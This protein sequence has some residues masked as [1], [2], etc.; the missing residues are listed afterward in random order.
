MLTYK[1]ALAGLRSNDK[2]QFLKDLLIQHKSGNENLTAALNPVTQYYLIHL[3]FI[4]GTEKM[5]NETLLTLGNE[6]A[7]KAILKSGESILDAGL[8]HFSRNKLSDTTDFVNKLNLLLEKVP[9]LFLLPN[10]FKKLPIEAV[11]DIQLKSI[12]IIP[13]LKAAVEKQNSNAKMESV[14]EALKKPEMQLLLIQGKNDSIPYNQV[15]SSLKQHLRWP[16]L[17][18]A[19][20]YNKVDI[21]KNIALNQQT[22]LKG[23]EIAPLF[24]VAAKANAQ[25]VQNFL[26]SYLQHKQAQARQQSAKRVLDNLNP[27]LTNIQN[28]MGVH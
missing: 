14:I 22:Y 26:K 27:Q 12:L 8:R 25:D 6:H 16:T 3:V 1:D 17:L 21:I 24:T 2:E 7:L 19:A 5:L 9:G 28:Q 23:Q 20:Q 4:Y 18:S 11:K 13:T 10:K 15:D